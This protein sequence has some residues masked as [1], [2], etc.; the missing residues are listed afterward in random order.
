MSDLVMTVDIS[1]FLKGANELG[2]NLPNA[3]ADGVMAGIHIAEE[4]IKT[5]MATSKSGKIYKVNK[6]KQ[7]HQAS[8]P[9]E[10]PAMETGDLVNAI[11]G[12]LI[13]KTKTGATGALVIGA[14][15]GIHLEFGTKYMAPRPS[16]R[17]SFDKNRGRMIQAIA[18]VFDV[19]KGK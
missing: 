15:Y 3:A 10:S 17:V 2:A 1:Q 13:A 16:L 6:G 14:E 12:E 8:A 5:D 4:W 18:H 9:G 7:L 19:W 11:S